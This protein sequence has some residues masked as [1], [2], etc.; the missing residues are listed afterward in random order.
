[1]RR[2]L[3]PFAPLLLLILYLPGCALFEKIDKPR[4]QW[5]VAAASYDSAMKTA[6]ALR[7]GGQIDDAA[8]RK[9]E[10]V[11]LYARQCLDEAERILND[12]RRAQAD[13]LYWIGEATRVVDALVATELKRRS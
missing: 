4:E 2:L 11:R 7:R 1:M 9:V 5:A 12:P 13:A 6:I 3:I 10:S 8:Y